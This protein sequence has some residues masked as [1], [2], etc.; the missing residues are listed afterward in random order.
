MLDN[1]R[2]VY[3]VGSILRTAEGL[4]V[5]TVYLCGITP[6]PK[7]RANDN[8]PPYLSAR[9]DKQIAK[10][11]LGAERSLTMH[12]F[13][14]INSVID[15]LKKSGVKIIAL[16]RDSKSKS[17]VTYKTRFDTALIV[18]NE[19]DGIS[20]K[21]LELSDSILSIPMFGKKE[22]FNVSAATAMALFYIKLCMI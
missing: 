5:E 22:S 19:I 2:S 14:S 3:N 11:A 13:P 4:G 20:R 9:I 1:I 6:Y 10:T 8:R 17:I 21:T 18:G 7:L 15:E 12:Y 16:E